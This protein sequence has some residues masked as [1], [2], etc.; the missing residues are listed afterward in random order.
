MQTSNVIR[1]HSTAV[2]RV[3]AEPPL[4]I[5]VV[6]GATLREIVSPRTGTFAFRSK[7]TDRIRF[8]DN[9]GRTLRARLRFMCGANLLVPTHGFAFAAA[10][11]L[12]TPLMFLHP[13]G[14]ENKKAA[15]SWLFYH[16][17]DSAPEKWM[18]E[19]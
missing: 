9:R 5:E 10:I 6:H 19:I 17:F 18:L 3:S 1:L 7:N 12:E 4:L 16:D 11:R 8:S 13:D 15:D 14:V 2:P